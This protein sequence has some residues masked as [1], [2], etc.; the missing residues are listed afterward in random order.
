[1]PGED[2]KAWLATEKVAGRHIQDG[3]GWDSEVVRQFGV[4]E[5]PFSVVVAA[6]GTVLAVNEHG[7]GLEKAVAA[8]L[9]TP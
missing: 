4:K 9:T 7:K 2:L 1:M 6:D 5:I 3:A 8:A